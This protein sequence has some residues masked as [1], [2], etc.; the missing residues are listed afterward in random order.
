MDRNEFREVG[1]QLIDSLAEYLDT[2]EDRPVF[3]DVAPETLH[4]LFD[5]RLPEQ[6]AAPEALL[7]ELDQKFFPYCSHV[8]H[9]GY[10]GLITPSPTPMGILGD[11]IASAMN[12]NIGA[13]TIGPSGVA[14][15]RRVVRWLCELAGYDAN[16]DG[17]LTSGGMMANFVAL[18]LAR[19]WATGDRAQHEGVTEPLAAYTSEERHISVDKSADAVGIGRNGLRV[20]PT[21]DCF[22][23]RID[24]LEAA[25]ADDRRKGIRPFCIVAMG[26]STNTGAVDDLAA[27]RRIADREQAWLHVDA[28]YGGGL[29]ISREYAG[30][31]PGIELADS[32]TIDPHKWFFA[33][34]DAG[35]ILV[36]DA[37]RLTASFG[38]QP[39]YLTDEMDRKR[40]RYQYYVHSFEQSRRLRGLK[41]WL[42]FKRYGAAQIAAWIDANVR[43]ARR[44]Y[45]LVQTSD[46]FL[47]ATEPTMSAICIRY[48]KGD[49]SPADAAELHRLVARRV[50]E[51]GR[52]WFSTTVLKDHSYFRICPVNY[53]TRDEH[54]DELL[55]FLRAEC[56]QQI[57]QRDPLA[58]AR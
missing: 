32:V 58:A 36:R 54:M 18:K 29:L 34:L 41:V 3:P 1:H 47:A 55:A 24:A 43:Q 48:T 10:M 6:G 46:D 22:R 5:E 52:F 13:Y 27:L 28:A 37:R 14:L 50:E 9:P 57:R 11:L 40:E 4:Q 2:V 20:L 35:A 33:P 23:L 17:H 45:D 44:L 26:G 38:L 53:R 31:L 25:L 21:D 19:D 51:D 8:G 30:R 7:A 42:S 56:E 15:E 49:L 16:S 39:A 12:Q